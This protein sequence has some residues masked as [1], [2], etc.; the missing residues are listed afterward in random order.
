M[1][2]KNWYHLH[3]SHL[4]CVLLA[5]PTPN[6]YLEIRE[7]VKAPIAENNVR[8]GATAKVE[9]IDQPWR[10]NLPAMLT[11]ASIAHTGTIADGLFEA[12]AALW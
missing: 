8:S 1:A 7:F 3:R 9:S 12:S 5:K 6:R 2:L 4:T 11:G 10:A